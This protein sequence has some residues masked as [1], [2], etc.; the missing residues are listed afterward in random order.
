MKII[1]IDQATPEW[2]AWRADGIGASDISVIIGSNPYKTEYR[3]W[4]EKCGFKSSEKLNEAMKHGVKNE[5]KARQ[6]INSHFQLNLIPLCVEDDSI[7]YFKGSL[8]GYDAATETLVEIK[9]PITEKTLDR[10]LMMQAVHDYW[11]DQVQWQIMLCAP[12]R[13]IL[14]LWDYRNNNCITVEIIADNSRIKNMRE[15]GSAFWKNVQ[16]G[17]TPKMENKDH[18]EIENDELSMFLS[19]YS[20]MC[21]RER[22][23]TNVKNDLKTKI[24]SFGNGN[25]FKCNGYTITKSSGRSSLD[26]DQMK[27]DGIDV[28]KYK[29]VSESTSYT[30]KCPQ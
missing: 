24:L 27:L 26:V 25:S 22:A 21:E 6:W 13:A 29:K 19:E 3:L 11:Y 1:E 23:A 4:E 16:L 28:E 10:A 15:R 9:C 30:I 14:A 5:E 20:D 17:K 12:K 2:H 18:E 8:D 7:N